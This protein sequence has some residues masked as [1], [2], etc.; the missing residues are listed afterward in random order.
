[1]RFYNRQKELEGVVD[2]GY[3]ILCLFPN[4]CH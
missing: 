4:N 2:G 3:V 1:M